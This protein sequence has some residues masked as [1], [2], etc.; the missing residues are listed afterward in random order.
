MADK[1]DVSI[2]VPVYNG[3]Q[4]LD[5]CLESVVEQEFS[6][7]L[8]ISIFNDASTDKSSELID[9]WSYK[10]QK[11]GIKF[12]FISSSSSSP[13]GVGFAKNE[14]V[15][16][17]CGEYLCFL[18]ADDVMHPCRVR[19]QYEACDSNDDM[20]VGCQ[21]HREP[22]DS[23]P[24][25]TNWANNLSSS[26]LYTQIYTAFGPT[27]VMPTWFCHRNVFRKVGGFSEAGKG[28]PEDLL[29]FYD[30]LKM[31][32]KLLRVDEDLLMYRYH[33]AATTFSVSEETV[34]NV[35][36]KELEKN[37]LVNWATF[38]IWNAGKQGRKF[39]RSLSPENKEKT[40]PKPRIPII[41]FSKA[42]PPF[43]LCVKLDMTGGKFEE[44]LASLCLIEGKDYFH[45]S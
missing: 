8:E 41:H 38:T 19:K 14:A 30:H 36:L 33:A 11:N 4:W 39:Y 10:I 32:G 17:S 6:G 25:Y 5:Q 27:I 29:F 7:K 20:I 26:Q 31:G 12:T 21:F 37:V 15:K 28:T 9:A 16:N 18:D 43:I 34:W 45:F 23:T 13:K 35:R 40:I 22:E 2:I 42:K 44:N 24:R 1:I 3:E